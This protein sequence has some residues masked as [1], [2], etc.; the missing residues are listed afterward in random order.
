MRIHALSIAIGAVLAAA[1]TGACVGSIGDG[2]NTSG[3]AHPGGPG[4]SGGTTAD[5]ACVD[6]GKVTIHRLNNTEYDNTVHDLL[7]DTTQPAEANFPIDDAAYGFDD[8]LDV[9]FH[10]PRALRGVRHRRPGAR[11]DGGHWGR[12]CDNHDVHTLPLDSDSCARQILGAIAK[13]AWRRPVTDQEL[14]ELLA[15]VTL[16]TQQGDDF[17][18]G[19]E[20]ALRVILV[21]PNFVYRAEIDPDPTSTTAHPL[22]DYELA[23][24]LSYFLWSSMPDDALFASADAGKLTGDPTELGKQAQRM[25]SDPK[26]QGLADTSRCSGSRRGI[27]QAVPDPMTYLTFSESVRTSMVSETR[28]FMRSFCS[29]TSAFST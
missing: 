25:L 13:R 21:S 5:S 12:P 10:Q 29:A 27:D 2:G 23:S 15:Q 11:A 3:G 22:N 24:R 4:S 16:A 17:D 20:Q 18:A 7:G 19:I 1:A 14:T 9:L 26:A 8:N 28:E 6:V